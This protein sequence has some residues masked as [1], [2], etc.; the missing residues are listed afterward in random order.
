M[1]LYSLPVTQFQP[2]GIA[3]SSKPKQDGGLPSSQY[4]SHTNVLCSPSF[5]SVSPLD[6]AS[7]GKKLK[8]FVFAE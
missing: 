7:P 2:L 8:C 4:V 6:Q 1:S 5:V 3:I